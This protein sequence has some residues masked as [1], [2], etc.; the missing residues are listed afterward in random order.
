MV[1]DQLPAR[2]HGR[3]GRVDHP[4]A[5]AHHPRFAQ[6]IGPG[7]TEE[8]RRHLLGHCLIVLTKDGQDCNPTGD[9]R[10]GHRAAAL[11]H[12]TRTEQLSPSRKSD[13]GVPITYLLDRETPPRPERT[14][15]QHTLGGL[16]SEHRRNIPS[17]GMSA[18]RTNVERAKTTRRLLISAARTHF[19][20]R[21]YANTTLAEIARTSRLTTGA[22]YYHWAGKD[23][24]LRDVV[25]G[26]YSDLA[27]Q[28][29][30]T[31]AKDAEP[32]DRLLVGGLK[33]IALCRDPRI[34]QLVL[35]DAPSALGY[36]KWREIDDRWWLTSTTTL[37]QLVHA[38][39]LPDS[40]ARSLALSLLGCLTYLG[41]EASTR[42]AANTIDD[43]S[44]AYSIMLRASIGAAGRVLPDATI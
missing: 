1:G 14:P 16:D 43:L 35:I 4:P 31:T 30:A 19:T 3:G 36:D 17:L 15:I 8:A 5:R 26:I 2:I 25:H 10:E 37:I 24:L 42:G 18:R 41:R 40:L 7:R 39:R 9:I 22:L 11:Q 6:E 44:E 23:E 28:I 34:A 12:P 27:R 32:I 20:E 33:F 13:Q 29:A 21:G 38:N